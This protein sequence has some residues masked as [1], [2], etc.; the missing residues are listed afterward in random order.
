MPPLAPKKIE[1][2][3][4]GP[5]SGE[6]ADVPAYKIAAATSLL[7][8][9]KEVNDLIEEGYTPIGGVSVKPQDAVFGP[10]FVQGMV[11]REP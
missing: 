10:Q 1:R 6:K 5:K 9:A 3:K 2:E 4:E 7:S 8:L 11:K